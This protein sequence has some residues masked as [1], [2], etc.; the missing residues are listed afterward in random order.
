MPYFKETQ[1][2]FN[3]QYFMKVVLY[4]FFSSFLFSLINL[5]PLFVTINPNNL[6]IYCLALEITGE[7]NVN[8]S[9]VS[10]ITGF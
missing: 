3:I 8:M 9:L 6:I 7:A 2:V 1:F 4:I 5:F 10:L